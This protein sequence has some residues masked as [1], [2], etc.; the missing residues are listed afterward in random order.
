MKYRRLPL[1][2]VV[3]ALGLLVALVGCSNPSAAPNDPGKAVVSVLLEAGGSRVA[4]SGVSLG[5]S[6]VVTAAPRA[7]K[8]PVFDLIEAH[9]GEGSS[10][11]EKIAKLEERWGV[12]LLRTAGSPPAV[13]TAV[14]VDEG[15]KVI[16]LGRREG[17]VPP[18][19]SQWRASLGALREVEGVVSA[20]GTSLPDPQSGGVSSGPFLEVQASAEPSMVGG[21][22]LDSGRRPVA[23]VR[24]V[25]VASSGKAAHSYALPLDDLRD[26]ASK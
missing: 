20:V 18:A 15:D 10:G 22:V 16:L 4:W 26:W 21:L 11:G 9:W 24:L 19:Q 3:V 7:D 25:Q 6:R 1:L 23:M 5:E 17:P 2:F 14:K 8:S 13:G 12:V